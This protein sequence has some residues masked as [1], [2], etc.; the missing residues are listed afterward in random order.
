VIETLF[1]FRPAG[2]IDEA[3]KTGYKPAKLYTGKPAKNWAGKCRLCTSIRQF[4]FDKGLHKAVVGP[5][6]CYQ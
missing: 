4:F 1:H 2:L 5:A 6:E 3:I